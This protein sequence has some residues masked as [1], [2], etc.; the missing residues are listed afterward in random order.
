MASGPA[1]Q[2][3]CEMGHDGREPRSRGLVL[4][5]LLSKEMELVGE[6]GYRL[7]LAL[8]GVLGMR[9]TRGSTSLAGGETMSHPLISTRCPRD[10]ASKRRG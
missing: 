5:K 1:Q 9:L 4:G 8:G 10:R 7:L 3:E 2:C 6:G